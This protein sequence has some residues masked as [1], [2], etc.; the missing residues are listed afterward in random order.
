M[1][2]EAR[3][4]RG[5]QHQETRIPKDAEKFPQ[6]P[7]TLD[8]E[9]KR[10]RLKKSVSSDGIIGRSSERDTQSK[11]SSNVGK[12]N[13]GSLEESYKEVP[14]HDNTDSEL[15]ELAQII[16]GKT[17]RSSDYL[18]KYFKDFSLLKALK[19]HFL[20]VVLTVQPILLKMTGI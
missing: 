12:I 10:S 9:D 14:S 5:Q 11:V 8:N 1:D 13:Q 16:P 2:S 18:Y 6:I 20:Q 15:P 19:M 17:G 4:G 7:V 3:A